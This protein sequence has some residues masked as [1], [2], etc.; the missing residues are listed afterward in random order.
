MAEGLTKGEAHP[1]EDE[2]I[3]TKILTLEEGLRWIRRG[4]IRDSKSVAGIL[5]YARFVER[6][7]R[8]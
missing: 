4:K 7:K 5:Y 1:E 2:R 8:A 3:T 6:K